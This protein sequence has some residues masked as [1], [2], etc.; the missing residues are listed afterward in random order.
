MFSIGEEARKVYED[1]QNMLK[2]LIQQKKLQARGVVGFWPAQS[3]QDDIHLYSEDA[4]PEA[5]EP[6]A[7]FHGLRQQAEKDS[8]STD[9]YHCLADFIAP[10]HS[11]VRD[12]LGLFVVACFGVDELSHAYEEECD[13]YS[14]IMAKALG[15]RLAEAFAE[16]L[17]ERVRRELWA[18]CSSEQL[19]TADLRRL[20]YEGIRPAPGY[21]SQPDHT[22]KLTMWRLAD[23]ERCTGIRLTESLAMSPASAVSGLYFS[24]PK[25]KYFAVGKISKD[26]IEDYALRKNMSVAEA[27]KWLGPI[28]GYDT[29]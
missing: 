3:I 27:E 21:P 25:S 26:Q 2:T 28:L 8:A 19:N 29:D 18:Y 1:A 17:H 10:L 15:D 20:R 16:E 9:A 5:A 23:V 11:G 24:N 7:T 14:S 13:D 22:E 4:V 6:I 12:Y